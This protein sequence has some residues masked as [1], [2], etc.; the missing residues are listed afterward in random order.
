MS[1]STG[2]FGVMARSFIPG[3]STLSLSAVVLAAGLGLATVASV[4]QVAAPTVPDAE[5]QQP[6]PYPY[7]ESADAKAEVDAALARAKAEGKRVLLDFGGNWCGDCRVLAAVSDLPEVKSFLERHYVFVSIDVG[8][9][10]KNMDI[11]ARFGV[12][13]F[14]GVPT[15]LV[16]DADGA[17]V[18]NGNLGDLTDARHMTPQ[19]I[20]DYLAKWA[21]PGKTASR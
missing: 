9:Y 15:I 21:K 2:V 16:V 3:L 5:L 18:N 10:T 14:K 6:L 20:V 11:P 12:P 17:L 19:A 4:A 13:T 1:N 8:R 7:N